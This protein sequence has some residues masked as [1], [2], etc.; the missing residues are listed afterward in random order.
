MLAQVKGILEFLKIE[1]G[2]LEVEKE[3]D[4][5]ATSKPMSGSLVDE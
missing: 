2:I 1:V 3:M 4:A 5:G